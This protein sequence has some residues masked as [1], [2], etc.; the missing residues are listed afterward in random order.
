MQWYNLILFYRTISFRVY[1]YSEGNVVLTKSQ[2]DFYEDN[3]YLV[4]PNLV[5]SV[6]LDE[7]R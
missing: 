3:G 6:L 7:M 2:R 5:D 4:I 1:V